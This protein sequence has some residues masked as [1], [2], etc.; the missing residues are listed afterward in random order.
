LLTRKPLK[1]R[2]SC[3]RRL[4]GEPALLASNS[5]KTEDQPAGRPGSVTGV[6]SV[7]DGAP[8]ADE[9]LMDAVYGALRAGLV[10]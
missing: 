10:P 5:A 3:S 8:P 4:A 1:R 2:N 6:T 9:L 7:T